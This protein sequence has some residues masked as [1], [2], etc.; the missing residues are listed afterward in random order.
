MNK[1]Q[2]LEQ[3]FN[4]VSFIRITKTWHFF[5][6]NKSMYISDYIFSN[7]YANKDL[8]RSQIKHEIFSNLKE[9]Y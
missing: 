3:W 5:Y 1:K 9:S 8:D 7:I 4:D 2:I 6:K